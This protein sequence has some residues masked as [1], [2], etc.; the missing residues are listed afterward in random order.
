MAQ[1]LIVMP[2]YFSSSVIFYINSPL[3]E[4]NSGFLATEQDVR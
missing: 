1:G 2:G 3:L 4:I